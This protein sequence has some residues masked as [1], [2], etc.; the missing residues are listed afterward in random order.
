MSVI[1]CH[2]RTRYII[3]RRKK[4]MKGQRVKQSVW[5]IERD[6]QRIAQAHIGAIEAL[7]AYERGA[8][9]VA[10]Q[11]GSRGTGG[12]GEIRLDQFARM[13]RDLERQLE[14]FGRE[15]ARLAELVEATAATA[16]SDA[17]VRWCV[18]SKMVGVRTP[19]TH[20]IVDEKGLK[21]PVCRWAYD[22]RRG[23]GRMP[24]KSEV[25]RHCSGRRLRRA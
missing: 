7:K 4:P 6:A 12:E 21:I 13:R 23:A 22:F 17:A 5:T 2:T 25:E 24:T 9:S 14:R 1:K 8:G 3:T 18:V 15:A 10:P 19:A 20:T 16:S 11:S